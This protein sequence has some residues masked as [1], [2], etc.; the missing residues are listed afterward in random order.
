MQRTGRDCPAYVF[1]AYAACHFRDGEDYV[2]L[3]QLARE[4]ARDANVE[5]YWLAASC[6]ADKETDPVR[7]T[8]DVWRI[9]DVMRGAQQLVVA[10]GEPEQG[11]DVDALLRE[12]AGSIWTLPEILLSPERYFGVYYFER[13]GSAIIKLS[14]PKNSFAG[15]YSMSGKDAYRV[16]RLMD[17]YL[18][19]LKLSDMELMKVALEC[20]N[21]R[22][23]GTTGVQ[24]FP[25]DPAY[26]MMGL[27]SR[28]PPVNP[29]DS[30]FLAFARLS[31][32][33]Y[34][35]QMFERLLC[36]LPAT[37]GQLWHDTEDAYG[38][39][40]WDIEPYVQVAGI[41]TYNDEEPELFD[42][43]LF[44]GE[45]LR[46][47]GPETDA[48]SASTLLGQDAQCHVRTDTKSPV[49]SEIE[50]DDVVILDGCFAAK[51]RWDAF[52]RPVQRHWPSL[53]RILI[54]A[55]LFSNLFLF[56]AG[57]VVSAIIGLDEPQCSSGDP[58]YVYKS[59]GYGLIGFALLVYLVA[60]TAY[61]F[62]YYDRIREVEPGFY[63]FEG[64]MP[65]E[66]IERYIFGFTRGIL[67]WSPHASSP[68]S[69]RK[70]T[71]DGW[72]IP[73]DPCDDPD[74]KKKVSSACEAG[75]GDMRVFTLVD[76]Y[77]MTVTLFEARRP[78]EAL[79]LCGSEGGMQRAL[80]CSF[81]WTTLTFY[82]E[83][84]L[85]LETRVLSRMDR[86]RRVRLGI[87][88]KVMPSSIAERSAAAEACSDFTWRMRNGLR[89][90]LYAAK[91]K[92]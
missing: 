40:L 53:R 85:R 74:T 55:V 1:I 12:F 25:G 34:N 46:A 45:Y 27:L 33:N 62:V 67:T 63:G 44:E 2:K 52:R 83:T 14:K 80:A 88:R 28:R 19:N 36:L 50:Q 24:F 41:G 23:A 29:T 6:I 71:G 57:V 84:V 64:Y 65:V 20:F 59:I 17:H 30:G 22:A 86:V 76:T 18:G 78:P 72:I 11:K 5:C 37:E 81:E 82:K 66:E 21:A 38:A 91:N 15:S 77:S 43:E 9:S 39:Q 73:Q 61:R 56:A 7:H 35:D 31:M 4:A 47:L 75:P 51:V 68:L 49:F 92:I 79:F 70:H 54:R 60:P 69:V 90:E 89:E 58:C 3:H 10:P 32:G 48:S 16:R 8:L 13:H 87:N 26:A 42:D